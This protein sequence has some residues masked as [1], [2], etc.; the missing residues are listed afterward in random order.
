VKLRNLIVV[1]VL[2]VVGGLAGCGSCAK[3]FNTG[4]ELGK[5]SV[6]CREDATVTTDATC[7]T[8]CQ[9]SNATFSGALTDTQG[10]HCKCKSTDATYKE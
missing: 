4:V 1:G 6:R 2:G 10:N 9:K 3:G 7:A 8:C 5:A